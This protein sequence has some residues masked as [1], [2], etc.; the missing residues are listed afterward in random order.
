MTWCYLQFGQT[1]GLRVIVQSN[2]RDATY[3]DDRIECFLRSYRDTVL[4]CMTAETLAM[5]IAAVVDTLLEKPKNLNEESNKYW[6]EIDSSLYLFQRNRFMSEYLRSADVSLSTVLS[7]FDEYLSAS[8]AA[9]RKLTSQFFGAAATVPMTTTMT[10]TMSMPVVVIADPHSFRN[11]MP[12]MAV[13]SYRE[14]LT[15]AG[16]AAAAGAGDA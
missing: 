11:S 6:D 7:F 1:S 8:S 10:T 13:N 3:L 9:R 2:S 16:A 14:H 5:N 12:L 15:C 4:T